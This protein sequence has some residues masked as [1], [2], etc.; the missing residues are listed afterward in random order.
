[1]SLNKDPKKISSIDDLPDG[2]DE[3]PS[4]VQPDNQTPTE[5][6]ASSAASSAVESAPEKG[7]DSVAKKHGNTIPCAP[8]EYGL[9]ESAADEESEA[10]NKRGDESDMN[11]KYERFSKA[12][13]I[14]SI[15]VQQEAHELEMKLHKIDLSQKENVGIWANP[16]LKDIIAV[17]CKQLGETQDKVVLAAMLHFYRSV[18][19]DERRMLHDLGFLLDNLALQN[20]ELCTETSALEDL[21]QQAIELEASPYFSTDEDT[22]EGVDDYDCD[23]EQEGRP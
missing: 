6:G 4:D 21:A 23:K 20:Q 15:E 16:I 9:E 18:M 11:E 8:S 1:M 7:N 14:H 12:A 10:K 19:Q 2:L 22:L 17:I 13:D 3:E 5:N